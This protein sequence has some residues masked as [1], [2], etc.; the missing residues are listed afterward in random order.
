M[1]IHSECENVWNV[2]GNL[3]QCILVHLLEQAVVILSL[4]KK[5]A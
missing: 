2:L 5:P 1:V 3:A 4:E